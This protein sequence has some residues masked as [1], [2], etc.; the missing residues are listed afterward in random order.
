MKSGFLSGRGCQIVLISWLVT[1]LI[2]SLFYMV[3]CN[4]QDSETSENKFKAFL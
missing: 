4:H 3:T 2:F 1:K